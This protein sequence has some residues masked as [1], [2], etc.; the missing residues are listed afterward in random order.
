MAL[1][2]SGCS[3]ATLN[4]QLGE[5]SL[6]PAYDFESRLP[7][8][9]DRLFIV[10]AFSGGGTRAVM[11]SSMVPP[12]FAP[13]RLRNYPECHDKTKPWIN[14]A[15]QDREL[16]SRKFAVAEGLSRYLDHEA[17]PFLNLADG[18]ITDN[19]GVR[20][21]M[22]SPVAHLGD[23]EKMAGAFGPETLGKVE[24]VLV[25]LVNAQ[26]YPPYP[27]AVSGDE[28]GTFETLEASFDA[29]L[30][31]LTRDRPNAGVPF[32]SPSDFTKS[33]ENTTEVPLVNWLSELRMMS[34]E[35][36]NRMVSA[37]VAG[38]TPRDNSR[39]GIERLVFGKIASS[40]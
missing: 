9:D 31:T 11:A 13:L 12:A 38:S 7:D 6:E 27:W 8:N 37:A 36:S 22:M 28:P 40:S 29:A 34:L 25:V 26:V 15:L 18:G 5:T 33:D 16:L 1:A 2:I 35:S 14:Q 17:M 30:N 39:K 21:S 24:H 10:L 19:I 20:G 32:V 23:V 4:T 3:M